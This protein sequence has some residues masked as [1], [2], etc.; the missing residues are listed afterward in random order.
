MFNVKEEK[1]FVLLVTFLI[2]IILTLVG[3]GA[4]LNSSVEIKISGNERLQKEAFFAADAGTA[5]VPR[6]IKY[7]LDNQPDIAG[8]PDNLPADI[9]AIA[10][11]R[12]FLDEINGIF[13]DDASYSSP[14]IQLTSQGRQLDVDIDWVGRMLTEEQNIVF[15]NEDGVPAPVTIYFRAFSRGHATDNS[16]LDIETFYKYL[17]PY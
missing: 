3:L 17:P 9:K 2:M 11:D 14:D 5:I 7:Y 1:G 12:N 8:Y 13:Q 15:L 16:F 6:V 10:K 4:I